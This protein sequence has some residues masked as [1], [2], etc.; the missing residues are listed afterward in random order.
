[1]INTDNKFVPLILP[2]RGED[3]I[4]GRQYALTPIARLILREEFCI[5]APTI[6]EC[7]HRRIAATEI[8]TTRKN[9]ETGETTTSTSS[10]PAQ[11]ATFRCMANRGKILTFTL[12]LA[13]LDELVPFYDKSH[14]LPALEEDWFATRSL[15]STHHKFRGQSLRWWDGEGK[16]K[17][18]GVGGPRRKAAKVAVY[19]PTSY[20]DLLANLEKLM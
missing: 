3:L 18:T 16:G 4:P 12:D 1:M 15:P 7:I 14:Q 11:A 2:E 5:Q 20:E 10:L 19:T 8:T 9:C 6:V 17:H 13:K